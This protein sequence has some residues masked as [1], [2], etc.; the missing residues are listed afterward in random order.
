LAL[1]ITARSVAYGMLFINI[2]PKCTT[3]LKPGWNLVSV[4]VNKTGAV[5]EIF[6]YDLTNFRYVLRWKENG[7]NSGFEVYSPKAVSNPFNLTE[8]NESYFILVYNESSLGYAGANTSNIEIEMPRGW[9]NPSWPYEF[10]TSITKYF[11]ESEHSYL[12][13]WN[14]NSQEF[15]IYSPKSVSNP[16]TEIFVGEGQFIFSK[17]AHILFY[18]RTYLKG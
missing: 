17:V 10:N 12:M 11:N 4:C 16:F 2:L 8:L 7:I 6:K 13:K 18:N 3:D 1:P 14:R 5:D 9:N 15:E